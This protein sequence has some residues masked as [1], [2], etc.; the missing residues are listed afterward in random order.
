MRQL[1]A[2]S[3]ALVRVGCG[4]CRRPMYSACCISV[5][6]HCILWP[7]RHVIPDVAIAIYRPRSGSLSC[8]SCSSSPRSATSSSSSSTLSCYASASWSAATADLLGITLLLGQ[9]PSSSMRGALASSR[10]VTTRSRGGF[11][12]WD[13][14]LHL[15]RAEQSAP[16][17]QSNTVEI[18]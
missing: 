9:M 11:T 17:H 16:L 5:Y 18:S 6:E 2:H 12:I 13:I 1:R 14:L 8:L 15:H 4:S 10:Q 7:S 3:R